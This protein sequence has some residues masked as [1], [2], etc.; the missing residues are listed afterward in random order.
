MTPRA[1]PLSE[2]GKVI[3]FCL[4]F[5]PIGW[6]LLIPILMVMAIDGIRNAWLE[7]NYRRAERRSKAG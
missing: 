1:R 5:F 7:W 3:A 4:L 6:F 2:N